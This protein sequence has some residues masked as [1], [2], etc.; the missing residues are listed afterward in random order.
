MYVKKLNMIEKHLFFVIKNKNQ[1]QPV[2]LCND[3]LWSALLVK[4][5]DDLLHSWVIACP[6][7]VVVFTQ[8][9][10]RDTQYLYSLN[11]NSFKMK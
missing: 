6:I 11:S 5:G 4:G 3:L 10:L 8:P 9:R 7:A 1:K 2:F